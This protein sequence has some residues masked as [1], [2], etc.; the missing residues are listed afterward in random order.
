MISLELSY[1]IAKFYLLAYFVFFIISFLNKENN[2]SNFIIVSLVL[3]NCIIGQYVKELLGFYTFYLGA[4]L[5]CL[6]V[7]ALSLFL[8]LFFKVKHEKTT[9]IIYLFYFFIALSFL[10]LH[11]VRVVIYDSDESILWLIN[12]QSVFTL[13]LYFLSI[14][15]LAFGCKNKWKYFSGRLS[16]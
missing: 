7:I 10:I 11:R 14:I 9:Y 5:Q 4:T 6:V 8:H 3:I 13:L 15:V 12:T 16:F 2:K 1:F